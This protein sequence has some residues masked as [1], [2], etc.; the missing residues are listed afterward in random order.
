[1][2]TCAGASSCRRGARGD[3]GGEQQWWDYGWPDR[4]WRLAVLTAERPQASVEEAELFRTD[5]MI[6]SVRQP[7]E[8]V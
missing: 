6:G 8:R 5:P 2:M 1:L 7:K 3:P 4:G